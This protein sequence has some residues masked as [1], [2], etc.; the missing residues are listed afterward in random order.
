MIARFDTKRDQ[1]LGNS[2]DVSRELCV[3]PSLI[4][5]HERRTVT[6]QPRCT[7]WY[8]AQHQ[9]VICHAQSLDPQER[10]LADQV[11]HHRRSSV[12]GSGLGAP[13]E[14]DLLVG[15]GKVNVRRMPGHQRISNRS[16]SEGVNVGGTS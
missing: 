12:G 13:F 10:P 15:S 2:I 1:T 6:P 4:A 14:G 9:P 5:K 11:S 3:S 7:L 8:V 16:C